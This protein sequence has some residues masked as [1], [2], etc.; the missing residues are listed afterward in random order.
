MP[1]IKRS[2]AA[3]CGFL[4]FNEWRLQ[5]GFARRRFRRVYVV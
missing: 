2:G 1:A 4:P 5:P 3:R